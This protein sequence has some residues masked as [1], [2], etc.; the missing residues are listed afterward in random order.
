LF[1][2]KAKRRCFEPGLSVG[3]SRLQKPAH[4]KSINLKIRKTA[5]TIIHLDGSAGEGGGQLLRSALSLSLCTG[6]PFVIDNIRAGR[7][8]PGLMRQHLACVKAAARIGGAQVQGDDIGSK[9]LTF[10]PG[11]IQADDYE[12]AIGSAGSTMLLLQCVLPALLHAPGTSTLVLQ[13]GTHNPL[14]PTADFIEH[15][16][17]PLLKTMGA[18]IEFQVQRPGFYPAG[19]GVVRLRISPAAL[20]PIHLLQRGALRGVTARATLSNLATDIA[21]RE[22]AVVQKK[23]QLTSAALQIA[24]FHEPSFGPAN[25]L[26]LFATHANTTCVVTAHGERARSAEQ[27]AESAIKQLQKFLHSEAAVDEHLADQ[28]LLP[29]ALAAGGSFTTNALTPHLLSN[30]ALIEQFLPSRF[31]ITPTNGAQLVSLDSVP[32]A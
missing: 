23:M 22:L 28:L 20:Q 27:V 8:K 3:K 14:A 30:I 31:A 6:T 2:S 29:M 9:R 19:G 26:Q 18:Q 21:V 1:A 17:L 15:A 24:Q 4:K 12:F 16:F 13:G 25:V 32:V 5:M 10:T 7:S 11:V